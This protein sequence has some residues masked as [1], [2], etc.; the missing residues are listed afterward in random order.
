MF[1]LSQRCFG[2]INLKRKDL[3]AGKTCKRPMPDS[4]VAF[5]RDAFASC[6]ISIQKKSMKITNVNYL[7]LKL[8][9]YGSAQWDP[10]RRGR[11][12]VTIMHQSPPNLDSGGAMVGKKY[13]HQ[14]WPSA[15]V[16]VKKCLKDR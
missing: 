15:A 4:N 6:E 12:S 14:S 3:E 1:K 7:A 10:H 2:R 13:W 8:H 5:V 16:A 9:H 11:A